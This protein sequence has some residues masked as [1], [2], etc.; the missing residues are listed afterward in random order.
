M[1][2]LDAARQAFGLWLT[3]AAAGFASAAHGFG[4]PRAFRLVQAQA[5]GFR[6]EQ[7]HGRVGWETLAD[8]VVI[9]NGAL[10]PPLDPARRARLR[11]AQVEIVL[12]PELFVVRPIRLPARAAPFIEGV[13]RNQ[14]DRLTPWRPAEAAFGVTAPEKLSDDRIGARIVA[15]GRARLLPYIDALRPYGV[16]AVTVTTDVEGE[17]E[18][19]PARLCVWKQSMGD[20]HRLQRWRLSLGVGLAASALAAILALAASTYVGMGLDDERASLEAAIS[21]RRAALI[22]A[23][24]AAQGEAVAALNQK[25]RSALPTVL[26]LEALTHA[27]PDGAYLTELSF[28]PG[29]VTLSGLTDDAPGLV[30]LIEQSPRFSHAAFASPTTHAPNESGERFHIEAHVEPNWTKAP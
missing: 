10:A 14:I 4:S 15:T 28:E 11:G 8:S 17:G 24:G 16:D 19:G 20:A 13:A 18:A 21:A 22:A 12:R 29:K 5:G 25:K 1:S 2:R 9:D 30:R 27:L 7:S 26:A 23:R 6:L 3:E